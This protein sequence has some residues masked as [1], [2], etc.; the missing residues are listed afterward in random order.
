VETVSQ[1]PSETDRRISRYNVR[2]SAK[3]FNNEK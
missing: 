3:A 2:L 1:I